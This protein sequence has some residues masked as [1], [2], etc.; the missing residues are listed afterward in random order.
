MHRFALALVAAGLAAAAAPAPAAE[1]LSDGK[2]KLGVLTDMTGYYADAPA[3][4]RAYLDQGDRQQRLIAAAVIHHYQFRSEDEIARRMRRGIGAD[5][6]GQSAFLRVLE[7][8]TLAGFLAPFNEVEDT[9]LRD[10]WRWV[11]DARAAS[12]IA[13]P[14]SPNVARGKPAT[15]SSVSPWS[16]GATP[17]ADAAGVVGGV[18]SGSYNCHT[19][20][21]DQPWWRV[22]LLTPHLI[23]Q[24]QVFNRVDDETFRWRAALFALEVSLDGET[25]EVL[26]QTGAPR[27]FGGVDGTPLIWTSDR[28]VY[29]RHVRFRL[30][31]RTVL[32]LDAVEIYETPMRRAVVDA[33]A[34]GKLAKLLAEGRQ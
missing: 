28:G 9:T 23:R 32:H 18:F 17:E 10:V 15:Q 7:T 3:S 31:A 25:W 30:L 2:V 33:A 6:H 20:E 16:R 22:D 4:A 14:S 1:K 26:A 19:A 8:G 29:A 24:I 27:D 11:L 5:F 13:R 21:E 34:Y 12:V